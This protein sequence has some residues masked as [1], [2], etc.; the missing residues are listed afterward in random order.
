MNQLKRDPVKYIRDRVKSNYKK[1]S[2]CRICQTTELL[3]FHHFHSVAEMYNA[4]ARNNN[5]SI[6]TAED[7]ITVRD[8][9]IEEHWDEMVHGCVTLCKKHHAALHKIYGKSPKL[10]TAPKQARWVEKQR[11][12]HSV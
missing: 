12:K 10:V 8:T 9:F 6:S 5:I 2:E 1:D 3:E 7:I 11:A 4:W